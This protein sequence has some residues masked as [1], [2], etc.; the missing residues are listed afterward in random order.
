MKKYFEYKN[1]IILILIILIIIILLNPK[2]CIPL[3]SKPVYIS[4]IDSIPYFVHDTLIEEVEIE[5]PVETIV[6]VEKQVEVP[7]YQPVDTML[8]LK[9]YNSKNIFS[10]VLTLSNNN[11]SI[12]LIDTISQNKIIGRSFKE[13]IKSKIVRD[14]IEIKESPKNKMYFGINTNFNREDFVRNVGVGLIF[15]TKGDKLFQLGAG[16]TNRTVDGVNG[17]LSPYINGGVYWKIK[18]KKEE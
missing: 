17:T 4:Q 6:E 14:T 10:N 8:I 9:D 3:R 7:V 5:V 16:V 2:G 1:I 12:T 15:K 13:K 11:G 18:I